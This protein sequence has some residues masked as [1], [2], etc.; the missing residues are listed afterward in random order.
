MNHLFFEVI[1]NNDAGDHT[2]NNLR[3]E[4]NH[5]GTENTKKH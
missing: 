2:E 4:K 3:R 1:N 5:Q